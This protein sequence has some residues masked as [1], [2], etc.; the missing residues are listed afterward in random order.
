MSSKSIASPNN[1]LATYRAKRD[2]GVTGEPLGAKDRPGE[3]LS[4]VIQKHAASSLHYDFRLEWDGVLVSWAVPKGPS[5]DPADKRMAIHVE[6]HPLSY[7]TFEGTIPPGQYGA[8]TVIVWDTGTWEPVDDPAEGLAKGKLAFRL[9][10]RKLSGLWELVKIA[11]GGE[12]QEP[13][14][15]FKKRDEHAR[16][17]AEYDVLQAL[18]DSVN[19][20]PMKT[21]R[22]AKKSAPAVVAS[23]AELKIT[24]GER[25]IDAASGATK[26]DLVHYY[27]SIAEWILPHLKGRPC[28]LVRGPDGVDGQLFFQKHADRIHIPGIK[29]LDP[30]LWPEHGALLEV[31]SAK[32]LVGSAQMNV[33]ELHTWNSTSRNIDKPNRLIFD[34]DPGEGTSWSDVQEG[35]RLVHAFLDDLGLASWL[36]TSGGKGLHV[37]VPLV[38]KLG[39]EAVKDFSQAVVQQ[40]ARDVP[41]RFV[42]K[43]GA[44]NRIGKVFVDYLRNGLGATTAVAFSARARPGLGVSMPVAWEE[45]AALESG[46][47]WTIATARD[48]VSG[49]QTDPWAGY[50]TARNS[51]TGAIKSLGVKAPARAGKSNAK[52]IETM[53][54]SAR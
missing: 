24:H 49:Q 26:M 45:L 38:P 11:K 41:S 33:V 39:F 21:A 7:G 53:G 13:W 23:A 40:L 30:A 5:L 2:F 18:P 42:A 27:E 48:H 47:Q 22:V 4:F 10:G 36:K 28:S 20:R 35:A 32:A 12:R 52:R 8:G 44:A 31:G 51:L 9:R 25:V 19:A 15:L 14:L 37:V 50:R 16:P 34:L 43:S 1:R 3:A 6:D 54:V 29:E 46:A 17:R